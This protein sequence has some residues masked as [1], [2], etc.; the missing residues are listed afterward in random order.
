M[1]RRL[2]RTLLRRLA[3]LAAAAIIGFAVLTL[4]VRLA[5]PHAEGLR[6]VLAER[7]GDALGAE[8]TVETLGLHLRGLRPELSLEGATL[9]DPASGERLLA[10]RALYV[11]L[12]LRASLRA[13][14]PRIDGITLVGAH[15]EVRREGDGRIGVR[16]LDRLG[17]GDGDAAAFF[18]HQG[19]FSLVDS[20]IA[21]TDAAAG[22]PTLDFHVARLDLR[23]RG[24]VHRLRMRG[25]PP[26]DPGGT[27]T[28]L[29]DLRGPPGRPEQW[30]GR[31]YTD[32]RGSDLAHVLRGRLPAGLQLTTDGL[33]VSSWN[34]LRN[35][36]P[37]RA[38]ARVWLDDL[39]L[40][41]PAPAPAGGADDG[42]ATTTRLA[43]GDVGA[44]ARWRRQDHGWRLDVPSV[45]LFG[46]LRGAE[47]TALRLVGDRAAAGEPAAV[48]GWLAG[49][50]LERL[51]A[52]G[53]FAA[54]AAGT[55]TLTPL[56][57]GRIAGALHDLRFR[58]GQSP[59]GA[60][61]GSD[62]LVNGRIS[63][64]G[65]GPAPTAGDPDTPPP[66]PA[67]PIPAV[68][69]LEL[70]FSAA[71]DRGAVDLSARDGYLDL[72]PHLIAPLTLSRLAGR[73]AWHRTADGVRIRANALAA[74]TPDV[75]TLS[76]LDL[77]MPPDT[78][79]RIDLHTHVRG[80]DADAVSRYLPA[81]KMD[82][83]LE[84]WLDRAIVAGELVS[85]DLL[86]RGPL[87]DFPF[88]AHNGSFQLVL[89]VRDGVLDYQPPRPARP[90]PGMSAAEPAE[91]QAA[92]G[93]SDWPRLE[94]MD[95][96][97]YF[98]R[99]RLDI[100]LAGARI[101]STRVTGGSARMPNLWQ[102]EHLRIE[103]EGTGP[104]TDGLKVLA[105]TPLAEKLGGI[106]EALAAEGRGRLRLELD[107]PLRRGLEFGYAGRLG[108]LEDA[109]VALRASE[110][111]F[112]DLAGS[113]R[114]DRSGL[115]AE[116]IAARLG[117]QPLRVDIETHGPE[118]GE[119]AGRTDIVARGN[120]PA[121]RLAE[122]LPSPWWGLLQGSADWQLRASLD[123]ADAA[124]GKPPLD[125]AL[126]SDL[127][128]MALDLPL[129]F[130]KAADSTRALRIDTRLVPEQPPTITARLGDIGARLALAAG[131]NGPALER[132]ALDLSQL[133]EAL[134][135]TAGIELR[136]R[137]GDVALGDWL[138]WGAEHASLL[139]AAEGR[140]SAPRLLPARLSAQS[141]RLGV[142]RFENVRA[143]LTPATEGGWRIGLE[144]D[145]NSAS[146]RLP[147]GDDAPV[148]VR[149]DTLDLAPLLAAQ[150][151]EQ[152]PAAA[153]PD[154]RRVP[155]LSLQVEALRRGQDALG[156]LRLELARTPTGVE[157]TDLSLRGPLV[158][159]SGSGQW[160]RDAT[161]Y[162]ETAVAVD[163][164][165][166]DLGELLRHAGYY[167]A[168]ADAPARAELALSWPG[169]PGGFRLPQARGSLRL[170]VDGGR[171]LDMEPGV[172]RMLGV[173][174]L[175]ALGRRL[176]LD[177]S[178]VLDAGFSFDRIQGD[179]VIGSGTARIG[180][181][182]ILSAT[183]DIRVR[184]S[185]D[186][187][188]QTFDQRVRV[189]PEIGSGV[190]IAGAVAGG[191][192]VGAAVLLADSVS[193]NAVSQLAS[194]EYQ[195]TGPWSEPEVRRIA[196]DDGVRSVPDLLL[197]ETATSNGRDSGMGAGSEQEGAARERPVSPFLDQN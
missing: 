193:G 125:L 30:S 62:W 153:G 192:L 186:L 38:T 169:G 71:P 148:V 45:K 14:A 19:H 8:L 124:A 21:W 197:P 155:P 91:Q 172:G 50:P 133:P 10:L 68:D 4:V 194:Y 136:G 74:D 48:N 41:R 76:R 112:A 180:Q 83:R 59:S 154:P 26:G 32:W 24:D 141:L 113:L 120:T 160:T 161:G 144:A 104:L 178:D 47:Q 173:L 103:A 13:W 135:E 195:V 127:R 54:P 100:E 90:G 12:S 151:A 18:L 142:L 65:L 82:D 70:R 56:L 150:Q 17:G 44:L 6:G 85:G 121:A 143:G 28:L 119:N 185:M 176:S 109:A 122:L 46:S 27:L 163:L 116:D 9:H 20:D 36:R 162:I 137:L 43:L 139:Q 123:N 97:L 58:L 37:T 73:I 107:V 78:A 118:A 81:S 170:D 60:P 39:V 63:D 35:G 108:L 101:L 146:V 184:G 1:T 49:L 174:N 33:H 34:D 156:R 134:P 115:H 105:E 102:P 5:L 77:L 129:P 80:G 152:G 183:A 168:L 7:L 157:A 189:T 94:D 23:N 132:A 52:I 51:A 31:L 67:G 99:R 111:R 57:T 40:Q 84:A 75:A 190:A 149:L 29:A 167:S 15:L 96:T 72:R 64:F 188:A 147:G 93:R 88:D 92:R 196:G 177:F 130:G 110:L 187:V 3:G 2:L 66:A 53:R 11:D 16:G 171:L 140:A 22:A 25:S 106:A 126:Q 98:D 89:R 191:P 128:G 164:R 86:L 166:P 158:T 165:S 159:A 55:E 138:Q 179:L 182:D 61:S 131:P 69:G 175:S 181:L 79:P 87:A 95:V 117:A 114:F 145:G 42:T